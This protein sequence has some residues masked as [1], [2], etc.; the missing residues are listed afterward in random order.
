MAELR[1]HPAA[2]AVQLTDDDFSCTTSG[3]RL[4][5]WMGYTMVAGFPEDH[6]EVADEAAILDG[7]KQYLAE[8]QHCGAV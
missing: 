8:L 7:Q 1:D 5:C 3:E 4:G 6:G 2:C